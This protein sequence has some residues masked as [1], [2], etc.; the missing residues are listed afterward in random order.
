[1]TCSLFALE[2]E[3]VILPFAQSGEYHLIAQELI[4]GF[5]HD[6]DSL[7]IAVLRKN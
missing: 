2:N 1:M 6:S 5:E 7:F 3:D 4:C